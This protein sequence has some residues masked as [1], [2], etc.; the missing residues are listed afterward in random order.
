[1]LNDHRLF[2]SQARP[3]NSGSYAEEEGEEP[4][5]M[6]DSKE[7]ASFKHHKTDALMGSQ[8]L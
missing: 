6:E 3:Q 1:M 2:K 8:S 7:R 5:G 4:E